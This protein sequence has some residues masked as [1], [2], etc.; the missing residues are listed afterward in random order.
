MMTIGIKMDCINFTCQGE[1]HKA[2]NKVCQDYSYS[3]IY[4]NGVAIAIVCDGHG[5]K[6][7]FRS[8]IGSRLAGEVT[9]KNVSIFINS[10]GSDLFEGKPYTS[11]TAIAT[12]ISNAQFEKESL[13][14][15]TFRQLFSSIIYDW[16]T[17]I[18]EHA[19]NTPL[20][21]QEL[22]EMEKNWIEDFNNGIS[23]EKVYG[24]TLMAYIQTPLYW[25]AFHIG[26]GKCLSF[27]SEAKCK[28]PIPWDERCFLN[29][30]TS[31]CD[32]TAIDE[33][34]YCFQGNGEFPIA[35]FLGSDGMDDSFGADENLVNFYVQ[36]AK[37]I[38][39]TDRENVVSEIEQT[40]PQL[41]KIG[42]K[43]DMSVAIVYNKEQLTTAYPKFL[44]WQIDSTQK[45][46][47]AINK[48][49]EEK[50]KRIS[51]IEKIEV[52]TQKMTIEYN[53]AFADVK[54][55]YQEKSKLVKRIDILSQELYG[56]N[57]TPYMDEIGLN[58]DSDNL[59]EKKDINSEQ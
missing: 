58:F 13:I 49:I 37:E 24:C 34:R 27:D 29:K 48:K 50:K 22:S 11:N 14:D 28:E 5:G 56:E 39:Q 40:L 7:Y 9:E 4:E 42:S 52:V 17:Q 55:L 20:T 16:N 31:L 8:D 30:T 12:Q 18:I 57:Y 25:F 1:S 38:V 3:K 6:R 2:T 19:K 32:S 23:L 47:S 21:E 54:K 46:I 59:T 44:A 43:D 53:Y 36:I 26:D 45:S 51:D 15:K 41:S 33:F 35:I 10:I